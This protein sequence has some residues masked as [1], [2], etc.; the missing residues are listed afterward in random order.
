MCRRGDLQI[1]LCC[2]VRFFLKFARIANSPMF[3]IA[4]HVEGRIAHILRCA[5]SRT[6]PLHVCFL[7]VR[8]YTCKYTKKHHGHG[9]S[10]FAHVVGANCNSPYAVACV[11]ASNRPCFKLPP[12]GRAN[13]NSPLR[14]C[15]PSVGKY[16][17]N[18]CKYTKN[19]TGMV[20]ICLRVFFPM[21]TGV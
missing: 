19:I 6:L 16:H 15:Y 8:K 1:A 20:W 12:C 10:M 5:S 2:C 17:V 13:Y 21:L 18:T 3:S 7:D 14:V 11:F 9:V 4:P